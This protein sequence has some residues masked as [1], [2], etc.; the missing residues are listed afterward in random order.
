MTWAKHRWS[1]AGDAAIPH[2]GVRGRG[3]TRQPMREGFSVRIV[4]FIGHA[5]SVCSATA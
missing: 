2:A 3:W 4:H 5:S 1:I